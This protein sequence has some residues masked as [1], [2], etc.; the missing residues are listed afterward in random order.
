MIYIAYMDSFQVAIFNSIVK[1]DCHDNFKFFFFL[2]KDF[3]RTKSTKTNHPL[4]RFYTHQGP[5]PLLLFVC[6]FFV[7]LVNVCLWVFLYSRNL[8]VKKIKNKN[9]Q[10]WNCLDSLI[11]LYCWHAPLSTRLSRIYLYALVFICNYLWESFWILLI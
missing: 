3:M 6:L 7:L 5:L 4:R 1:W 2:Q 11:S 9:K 10:T 8:F